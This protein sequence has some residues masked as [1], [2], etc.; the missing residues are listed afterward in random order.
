MKISI[1]NNTESIV[2][3][4]ID[5]RRYLVN[6]NATVFIESSDNSFD[7]SCYP[8]KSSDFKVLPLTKSVVYEYNF[9]LRTQCCIT[10]G[11]NIENGFIS[12]QMKKSKGDHLESYECI[13][14]VSN[15]EISSEKYRIQDEV[16]AKEKLSILRKKEQKIENRL[17]IIDVIQSALYV[18]IPVLILLLGVWRITNFIIA[19]EVLV[20]LLLIS[21]SVAFLIKFL[22]GKIGYKLDKHI[23][24]NEKNTENYKNIN[25]FFDESYILNVLNSD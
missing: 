23:K 4:L 22:I 20:P 5:D 16:C 2:Y 10:F 11:Q 1:I 15:G 8:D 18:G 3:L 13:K 19:L 21:V 12:L 9:I 25:S 17:K 7:I 6:I 14:I 24:K